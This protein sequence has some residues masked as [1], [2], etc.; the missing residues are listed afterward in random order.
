MPPFDGPRV[1]LGGQHCVG[2]WTWASARPNLDCFAF[3][4]FFFLNT[5]NKKYNC[6]YFGIGFHCLIFLGGTCN[7][8]FLE[9]IPLWCWHQIFISEHVTAMRIVDFPLHFMTCGFAGWVKKKWSRCVW[10]FTG[11]FAE[12]PWHFQVTIVNHSEL[13]G[14]PFSDKSSISRWGFP[15]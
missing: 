15:L 6:H 4:M 12:M 9:I 7:V 13:G 8:N 11:F 10:K 1:L 2:N 14:T 5:P 3:F